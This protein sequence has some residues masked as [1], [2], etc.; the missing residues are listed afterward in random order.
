MK[1]LVKLR[2][3]PPKL[4]KVGDVFFWSGRSDTAY[5]RVDSHYGRRAIGNASVPEDA[6]FYINLQNGSF[7]WDTPQNL[8]D[9]TT[10]L[11]PDTEDGCM[12]FKPRE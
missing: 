6:V 8:L 3:K 9:S 10:L 1:I 5:M 2:A 11:E 12:V 7:C 4:P